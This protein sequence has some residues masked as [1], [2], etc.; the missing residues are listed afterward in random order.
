MNKISKG[1]MLGI[2]G[3]VVGILAIAA[4]L[5]GF[6][7]WNSTRNE[8]VSKQNALI[9]QYKDNQN[10]L[11]S[12]VL[13]FNDS[14]GIADRQSEELN[15]IL[16]DAVQGRYDGK[17]N[18]GTGGAMFSAI[19]EAYPDLTANTKMYE[20]VQT[21]VESGREAYK[22]KQTRL[23]SMVQDFNTWR[24]SGIIKSQFI[25]LMGFPNSD[26]K[27]TVGDKSYT[28]MEALDKLS[29]PILDDTTIDAYSKGK[30]GPL[31]SPKK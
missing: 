3:A 11:S 29:N 13:K 1:M 27:I 28:G 6:A 20:K 31:V 21:L 19:Q 26:L 18:P 14:L 5:V 15:K 10:E 4:L 16:N 2:V 17:M 23:L 30:Q 25:S 8:G 9:A 12:Y 22:N 7:T 24:Q